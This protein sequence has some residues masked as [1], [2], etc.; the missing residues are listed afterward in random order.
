MVTKLPNVDVEEKTKN[1]S[2]S[3][4]VG[5]YLYGDNANDIHDAR[6]FESV[7]LSNGE[8]GAIPRP[9]ATD[10]EEPIHMARTGTP[11][12]TPGWYR[13][14]LGGAMARHILTGIG[15]IVTKFDGPQEGNW[16]LGDNAP[17]G[18]LLNWCGGWR[19][20][21]IEMV[22]KFFADAI[23]DTTGKPITDIENYGKVVGVL[24]SVGFVQKPQQRLEEIIEICKADA[25]LRKQ[26]AENPEK[27]FNAQEMLNNFDTLNAKKDYDG[28]MSSVKSRMKK[29]DAG[30]IF[31]TGLGV[32]TSAV[33][34]R[35]AM[36]VYGDI[37]RCFAE[38][39]AYEQY[40]DRKK[41]SDISVKDIFTCENKLVKETCDNFISKNILR[42]AVC[43]SFFLR[44]AGGGLLDSIG[45][46][47]N[48][49]WIKAL[50]TGSITLGALGGL[51]I[52]EV[53]RSDS[54]FF[55]DLVEL[56]DHK[57]NPQRGMGAQIN[58]SDLF[59]LY[60][61]YCVNYAK[62]KVFEDATRS[63]HDDRGEW[64]T[65]RAIFGRMAEMMNHTYKYKDPNY[66]NI[67]PVKQIEQDILTK[68]E[69][70]TLP[71]FIYLLS[72]DM[73]DFDKPELTMACAEIANTYSVQA[74]KQFWQTVN[75]RGV[76][77]EQALNDYVVDLNRTLGSINPE[78]DAISE[79]VP[80]YRKAML[81]NFLIKNPKIH[82]VYDE[83]KQNNELIKQ[84][85]KTIE[86]VRTTDNLMREMRDL[87]NDYSCSYDNKNSLACLDNGNPNNS[88]NNIVKFNRM[89]NAQ[90]Q[91]ANIAI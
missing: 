13:L 14:I 3:Y 37:H 65:S 46:G 47:E 39:V 84:H 59:D 91:T 1:N 53:L 44:A 78:I 2:D 5:N 83:I 69:Y 18:M 34:I 15:D 19:E 64:E 24:E 35:Y 72:H 73:I 60:Q 74:A 89:Q 40:D 48:H 58:A 61:K 85:G 6:N 25:A 29:N 87:L 45:Q 76:P 20:K 33:S 66:N 52:S 54:S 62:E 50:P 81:D 79:K 17:V 80:L 56:R 23:E 42:A 27:V 51:L 12:Q 67:D 82:E 68:M 16:L 21:K 38:V 8:R 10:L 26:I 49:Q 88:V 90:M 30:W 22:K 70:F 57:L 32:L 86:L 7:I 63:D 4:S 9:S 28:L 41:A 31:D 71:K 43:G 11:K 77:I 55:D 36:D 75:D